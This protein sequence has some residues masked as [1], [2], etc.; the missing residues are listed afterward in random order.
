M[1]NLGKTLTACAAVAGGAILIFNACT[2]NPTAAVH[3]ADVP[4]TVT[5]R[6]SPLLPAAATAAPAP[7]AAATEQTVWEGELFAP[8]RFQLQHRPTAAELALA[9]KYART[10]EQHMQEGQIFIHY[11][12]SRLK[13]CNLPVELAVI[14]LL[15]SGFDTRARSHKGALGPWQYMRRTGKSIGLNRTQNYDEIF[16]F[17]KTTE[18]SL[19]YLTRLYRDLDHNWDLVAAAYNQGEYGVKRALRRARAAGVREMTPRSI[20][21]PGPVRAYV[22]RFHAF[23]EVMRHPETYGVTLPEVKNRPAFKRVEIAGRINSMR[24]AANLAGVKLETLKHLNAGY[25]S[26]RLATHDD[27]GLLVPTEHAERLEN[28]LR[29]RPESSARAVR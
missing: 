2:V 23:A 11:L 13:E 9:R 17:V 10:M 22:Q 26:D 5:A 28:A 7:A 27:H 8:E 4:V 25:L 16:D 21:L 20:N 19:Q 15:E 3:A 1:L 6:Q 18:V 14:P 29:Y 24:E 12:L